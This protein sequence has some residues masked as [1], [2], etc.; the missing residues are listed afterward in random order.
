MPEIAPPRYGQIDH[1]YCQSSP[2]TTP[3]DEEAGLDDQPHALPGAGRLRRGLDRWDQRAG[4][5]RPVQ[6][7]GPLAA[8]RGGVVFVADVGA[9]LL[10]DDPVGPSRHR[11]VPGAA[12]VHRDAAPAGL[13]GEARPQGRRHGVDHRDG[14]GAVR[15]ARAAGRRAQVPWDEVPAP[16]HRGRPVRGGAAR[17]VLRRGPGGAGGDAGGDGGVHVARREGRRRPRGA[18][19]GVVR[20][21]RGPSSATVGGGTRPASTPSRRRRRSWRWCSTR[22]G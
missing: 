16:A 12:V 4:G 20:G 22:P 19:A 18:G 13:P 1:D 6:P 11:E 7:L 5:R 17:P 15:G 9:Q 21:W 3:A 8:I 2:A 14:R 10:G